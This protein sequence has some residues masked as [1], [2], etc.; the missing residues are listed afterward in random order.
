MSDLY[1]GIDQANV[2]QLARDIRAICAILDP[3][4]HEALRRDWPTIMEWLASWPDIDEVA[5]R[6]YAARM[7]ETTPATR[8]AMQELGVTVAATSCPTCDLTF[9]DGDQID[10]RRVCY[11]CGWK[12]AV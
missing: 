6:D 7:T 4:S 8:E 11:R 9:T 10:R 5:I 12:E 1:Q 3:V 2:D